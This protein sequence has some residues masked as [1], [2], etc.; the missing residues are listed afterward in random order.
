MTKKR[1]GIGCVGGGFV[2]KFHIRSFVGVRDADVLGIVGAP[3]DKTAEEAAAL[4]KVLNVGDAK[5]YKTIKD[6]VADPNIDAIWICSP[7]FTRIEVM[8]EI[9]HA[10][11]TGKGELIG[12]CCEKPLGRNVAEAKKCW[13]WFRKLAYWM[14]ISKINVFRQPW[15][16]AEILSG[17]EALQQRAD[18]TWLVPL[19]NTAVLTCPGSGKAHCRAAACSMI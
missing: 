17:H 13:N 4:A 6:M 19:K 1:L 16:G 7:N 14:A 10:V 3:N 18:R 12:V 8:E 15:F 9:A 2:G 11:Q 5:P